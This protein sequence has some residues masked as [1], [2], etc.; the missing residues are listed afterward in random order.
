MTKRWSTLSLPKKG[1]KI[2]VSHAFMVMEATSFSGGFPAYM[3]MVFRNIEQ[4]MFEAGAPEPYKW[5]WSGG[6][7]VTT[8]AI[9]HCSNS[10]DVRP[11]ARKSAVDTCDPHVQ[12]DASS[13]ILLEVEGA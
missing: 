2:S 13:P 10:S 4:K 3:N 9:L 6:D 1:E 7:G 5:H 8:P 12:L 11:G